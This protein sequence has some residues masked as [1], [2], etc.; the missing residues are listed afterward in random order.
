MKKLLI[1]LLV[2]AIILLILV[3]VSITLLLNSRKF[4]YGV[5]VCP[6][7]QDKKII[8]ALKKRNNDLEYYEDK[9][10][11][12]NQDGIQNSSCYI[13]P[14][15]YTNKIV[16][17][18]NENNENANKTALII[19]N[20]FHSKYMASAVLNNNKFDTVVRMIYPHDA[21]SA[22]DV[23]NHC[24]NGIIKLLKAGY[25]PQNISISGTS[26]GGAISIET[27]HSLKG[28][29]LMKDKKFKSYVNLNSF[30]HNL[31][32]PAYNFLSKISWKMKKYELKPIDK[33]NEI[34]VDTITVIHT[35]KDEII[36]D[37]ASMLYGLCEMKHSN[38]LKRDIDVISFDP[39]ACPKKWLNKESK[40]FPS[41][42]HGFKPFIPG[43]EDLDL[44]T[45]LLKCEDTNKNDSVKGIITKSSTGLLNI[46][47]QEN[48]T[49]ISNI[50]GYKPKNNVSLLPNVAS[51]LNQA[52]PT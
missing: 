4:I 27:M 28:H 12:N 46:N 13:Y 19:F 23:I 29:E 15:F 48:F 7:S 21:K 38:K 39:N 33:I 22:E 35:Q 47:N 36:R 8:N 18:T 34:P 51:N 31:T 45:P 10:T 44:L 52:L 17:K 5:F 25:D 2:V 42:N 37:K 40:I 16:Q 6:S 24:K 20:G 9:N 3:I 11:G 49:T 26:F 30:K 41:K 1:V 14:E 43:D 50:V 32:I